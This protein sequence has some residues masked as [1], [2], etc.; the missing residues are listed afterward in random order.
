MTCFTQ[1]FPSSFISSNGHQQ[2]N[3]MQGHAVPCNAMQCHAMPCNVI[4]C[5]A[6]PCNTMQCYTMPYNA[7]QGNA[8]QCHAMPCNAIQCHARQGK[9]LQYNGMW[10][11]RSAFD[12]VDALYS[13]S[14]TTSSPSYHVVKQDCKT[15]HHSDITSCYHALL[16]KASA[17]HLQTYTA[18]DLLARCMHNAD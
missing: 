14:I 10:H 8:M 17:S 12:D 13:K 15:C 5:H 7:M 9:A 18:Y 2:C 3:A 11:D 6:I 1:A 4:Q 16:S